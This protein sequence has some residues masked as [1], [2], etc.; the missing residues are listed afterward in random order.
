[1]RAGYLSDRY[2][3]KIVVYVSGSVMAA[4]PLTMVITTNFTI[5]IMMGLLFGLAY[6]GYIT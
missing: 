5:M 6:G 1:M 4:T 2:G 3:R